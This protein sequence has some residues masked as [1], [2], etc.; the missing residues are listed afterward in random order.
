MSGHGKHSSVGA[1][2]SGWDASCQIRHGGPGKASHRD[3]EAQAADACK[4]SELSSSLDV[5]ILGPRC[6]GHACGFDG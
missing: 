3:A 5:G 4:G 6:G 2:S 1:R